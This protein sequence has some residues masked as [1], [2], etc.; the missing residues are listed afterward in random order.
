MDSRSP[1]TQAS[2]ASALL[3]G[4]AAL[5]G[6][7]LLARVAGFIATA[8]LARR[9]G[10]AGFG[11]I[12]F[13]LALCSYPILAVN[14]GM[15]DIA[16]REVAR[17]PERARQIYAGVAT[18]RVMLAMGATGLLAVVAWFLPKPG[19]VQVVVLL[20]GLSFF[21]YAVNPSWAFKGLE[22]NVLAGIGLVLGQAIYAA[23]VVMAVQGPADVAVV[24]ILQFAG[25]FGSA[26]LLALILLQGKLP[27]I[28]V[29]EGLRILRSSAYLGLAKVLRTITITFDV[30]L[31][32]F[33]ATDRD[34]GL[35]TAAYRLTFLLMSVTT[36]LSS[37]YLPS[38]ARAFSGEPVAFRRLVETSLV[39]SAAV[40][41]PLVAGSVV[42]AGPLLTLLFGADYGAAAP[43]L[44]L[45][46]IS[47]G[48]IFF[49]WSASAVLVASHRTG[50]QA[51]IQGAAAAVTVTLNL[52][53]I[54]RLGIAGAAA[55]T[56]V[57]ELV[58]GVCGLVILR[59]IGALPPVRV[60]LPAVIAAA[61]MSMIVWW[62]SDLSVP[63]RVLLGGVVYVAALAAL[64]G[65]P[66]GLGR[67]TPPS[68]V[69]KRDCPRR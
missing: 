60:L 58:I 62:M 3:Q 10:P 66:S 13:A 46:A 11:I 4:V 18:V 47:V 5:A 36:S 61:L 44:Q 15:N 34:V 69:S 14:S 56:L 48:V 32:G 30:V 25:E 9:L 49:H 42:M 67:C 59:Q 19:V 27:S 40:G 31:L 45:L 28:P 53:L 22:R 68:I 17:A 37:A 6:G 33:L 16:T 50:L 7:E 65:L 23:G 51:K 20:Y 41:A 35:Y 38:Y 8:V 29:A 2:S 24:P 12:G 63:A 21:S 64:G 57:A 1:S 55:S 54:P 39:T 26:L 43:A 52:L